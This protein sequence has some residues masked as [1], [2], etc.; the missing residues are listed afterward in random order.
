VIPR[1]SS[2]RQ[3]SKIGH[4]QPLSNTSP[5]CITSV[6]GPAIAI[7]GDGGLD[8]AGALL[9]AVGLHSRRRCH[10]CRAPGFLEVAGGIRMAGKVA[11]W[12]RFFW[13]IGAGC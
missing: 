3:T 10:K 6:N 2:A 5:A 7:A 8:A 11:A 13:T 1:A 12:I 4:W 9:H